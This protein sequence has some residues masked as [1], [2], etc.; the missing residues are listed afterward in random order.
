MSPFAKQML[1]LAGC[2][3]GAKIVFKIA[4]KIDTL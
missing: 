4:E 3:I 1:M 2:Y